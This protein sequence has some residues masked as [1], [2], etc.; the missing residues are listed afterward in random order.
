LASENIQPKRDTEI[1]LKRGRPGTESGSVDDPGGIETRNFGTII[2][3]KMALHKLNMA[4][5]CVS[6]STFPAFKGRV[7]L[8]FERITCMENKRIIVK[9][10]Q[11]SFWILGQM[12]YQVRALRG[13]GR[14]S[15]RPEDGS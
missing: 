15:C 10:V 6:C 8:F 12:H 4:C 9:Y 1:F 5:F 2:S 3:P 13:R 7:N 14:S 11:M